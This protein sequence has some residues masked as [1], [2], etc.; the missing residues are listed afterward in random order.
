M[1]KYICDVNDKN[2]KMPV[3]KVAKYI[4][5]SITACPIRL[6][7]IL[8]INLW[9]DIVGINK[10]THVLKIIGQWDVKIHFWRCW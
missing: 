9:S 6:V 4:I 7:V 8:A 2:N 3:L 5:S 1:S 10:L